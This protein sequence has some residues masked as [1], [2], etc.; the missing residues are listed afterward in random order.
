M[1]SVSAIVVAGSAIA[2]AHCVTGSKSASV[3]SG[4]SRGEMKS[5]TCT[6]APGATERG[7]ATTVY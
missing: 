2:F 4:D 7:R 6:S 5:E 1:W 3:P